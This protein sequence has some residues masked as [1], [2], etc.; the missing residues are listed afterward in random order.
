MNL[1][2]NFGKDKNNKDILID[3]QKEHLHTIFMAGATGTGKSILHYYLYNQLMKNNTSDELGFI[4]M[5]MTQVDFNTWNKSYLYLPVIT[6]QDYALNALE[7]LANQDKFNKKIFVYIEE[8]DMFLVGA[9]RFINAWKKIHNKRNLHIVFSTSRPSPDIF[10]EKLKQNTD[11]KIA[12]NLS[13]ERDSQTVLDKSIAENFTLHGEKIIVY[14][15]REIITSPLDIKTVD[16]I[17]KL[18]ETS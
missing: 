12:F 10:T 13:S 6:D 3:L 17:N 1:K 4:F 5:D 14:K 18:Y 7:L 11:I 2:L 16:S 15:N 9:D 8:C